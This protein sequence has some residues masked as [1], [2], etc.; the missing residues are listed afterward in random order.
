ME[1]PNWDLIED[2]F[3]R[4][5]RIHDLVWVVKKTR[6]RFG[7]GMEVAQPGDHGLVISAWMSSMGSLKLCLVTPDLREV[8]I[9]STCARI[10]GTLDNHPEWS[11][12]R[13][14][15]MQKTFVPIIVM[16]EKSSSR[17]NTTVPFVI[18]RNGGAILVNPM[19]TDSKIWLNRD[20]VHPGDWDLMMA[21]ESRCHSVR[22]PVWVAKKAG[23]L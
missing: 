21:S 2:K 20:K 6:G 1:E 17:R 15:W 23:I 14:Q 12:I 8:G 9:T 3:I 5:A 4:S 16:R 10:W 19:G 18:S 22:V 13:L 7:P 11:D